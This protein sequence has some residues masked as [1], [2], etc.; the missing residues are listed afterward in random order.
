MVPNLPRQVIVTYRFAQPVDGCPVDSIAL[1]G[2]AIAE[3]TLLTAWFPWTYA[4]N[5]EPII[6]ISSIPFAAAMGAASGFADAGTLARWRAYR[7]EAKRSFGPHKLKPDGYDWTRFL[8]R[9]WKPLEYQR[10]GM[11][12]LYA[13]ATLGKGSIL[14]DDVGLGKTVQA[15]GVAE[16]IVSERPGTVLVVTTISTLSQWAE[17]VERFARRKPV[18]V[19]ADGKERKARLKKRHDWMIVSYET[20]RLPQ[21][22]RLVDR[23][24]PR[25]L[26]FDEAYK[27]ANRSTQTQARAHEL[28]SRAD[29]AFEFNATPIENG[30]GD[31]FGQLRCIDRNLLGSWDMYDARYLLRTDTGREVGVRHLRELKLRTA[32]VILRRTAHECGA[33]VPRVLAE[34]RP[35]EMTGEQEAAYTVAVGEFLSDRSSGAVAR[36]KLARVRY[37]AFAANVRDHDSSS[38]KMD[39]LL[40]MLKGELA[41]QRV[42]VFSRF[43]RVIESVRVRLEAV[44]IKPWVITGDTSRLDRSD[45]RRRFSSRLGRGKVL[46]GSE[47]IE[48]GMNLQTAGVMYN[49]DLPWNAGRLRQRVGRIARIGQARDRVLVLNAIATSKRFK[50]CDEWIHSIVVGKRGTFD[51]FFGDDGVDE[52]GT[53]TP[54]LAAVRD[55][56]AGAYMK[57]NG[58]R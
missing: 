5:G 8:T 33:E 37:A 10:A 7:D 40:A 51:A 23:L 47:A 14:G 52:L 57:A 12:R 44:G 26:I 45:I 17:E 2:D 27:L 9:A 35:C 24:T 4:P 16:R 49:L 56:L 3:T 30:A 58:S 53:E 41:G 32:A 15:I 28:A 39:D 18:V 54:N 55:Y 36:A 25:V 38:A 11:D 50:T 22:A 19:V 43:T 46:L 13:R 29:A 31:L 1:R 21:F 6:H 42:I 20:I 48:R 34:V